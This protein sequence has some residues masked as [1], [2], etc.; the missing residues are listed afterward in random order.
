VCRSGSSEGGEFTLPGRGEQGENV[1][2]P[3]GEVGQYELLDAIGQG[4]LSRVYLAH[5]AQTSGEFALK[6]FV[7]RQPATSRLLETLRDRSGRVVGLRHRNLAQVIELVE[8]DDHLSI[9]SEIIRG[10]TLKEILARCERKGILPV[11]VAAGI[12]QQLCDGLAFLHATPNEDGRS[13]NLVHGDIKPSNVIVGEDGVVKLTDF[14]MAEAEISLLRSPA[15]AMAKGAMLYLSPEQVRRA[16]P[17]TRSD[18][19]G[20]AVVLTQAITGEFPF[21][22]KSLDQV[23]LNITNSRIDAAMVQVGQRCAALVP[24]LTQALASRAIDRYSTAQ[25]LR[26]AI[27]GAAGEV[28]D[29][30]A[31]AAWLAEWSFD[32]PA[33]PSE[34]STGH[35]SGDEE[36]SKRF[37]GRTVAGQYRIKR[38]IGQG[39][40]GEVFLARQGGDAGRSVVVKILIPPPDADLDVSLFERLFLR[41]A[42]AAAG[43]KAPNTIT[44]Y[45]FGRTDDGIL[46]IVMEY[47]KGETLYDTIEGQGPFDEGRTTHVALQVAQALLEAHGRGIVHRDLKP[48]NVMLVDRNN[49]PNFA[50]VLDFGLVKHTDRSGERSELT[51][52]G[53]FLGSPKYA[54]P[55]QLQSRQDV[56]SRADVYAFGLLLYFMQTGTAP[57]DGDMRQIIASQLLSPPPPMQE[58]NPQ[59]DTS[60]ELQEVINRCL[61]K[62]PADRFQHMGEIIDT[63]RGT[64]SK[65]SW[66][67]LREN[68]DEDG[69]I[70]DSSLPSISEPSVPEEP[71]SVTF[72][73]PHDVRPTKPPTQAPPK[74]SK[75]RLILWLC[76]GIAAIALIALSTVGGYHLATQD[77]P[78]PG[79]EDEVQPTPEEVVEPVDGAII[80]DSTA[81]VAT[82]SVDSTPR[83]STV[84]L[85]RD[86]A[87]EVLGTTPLVTDIALDAAEVEGD[88]VLVVR[89]DGYQDST[90]REGL[91]D[92]KL[93]TSVTLKRPSTS[94]KWVPERTDDKVKTP[95]DEKGKEKENLR[96][97]KDDPY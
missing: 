46:Y 34:P 74:K 15:F 38:R 96:E 44:I 70:S 81:V 57:F 54:A 36:S 52:A 31:L 78:A 58:M 76:L 13:S 64:V 47:L 61:E 89:N 22:G 12:A 69:Y 14:G 87:E 8:T 5:H 84:S 93:V 62:D 49:D 30:P 59:L 48:V 29:P 55:E 19:F 95:G 77:D 83:N 21:G 88:L 68:Y 4:G 11:P 2:N 27:A 1:A 9:I 97:F 50:K 17:D 20:V 75:N 65:A 32:E 7:L 79:T 92:G 10:M 72:K 41:E 53:K 73:V 16:P 40:M 24:V 25:E 42:A 91:T 66:S 51:F 6:Q 71:V 3:V 90:I 23:L 63:L 45:D 35:S 86:G 18:L 80:I 85:V 26:D 43:L 94:K 56:D 28:A 67:K 82:V 37:V 60:P 33:S 39:G